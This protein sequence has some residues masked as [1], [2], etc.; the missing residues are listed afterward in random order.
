MIS[1]CTSLCRNVYI[2]LFTKIVIKLLSQLILKYGI[3]WPC[4]SVIYIQIYG[5]QVSSAAILLFC[6]FAIFN[7]VPVPKDSNE[8]RIISETG[9]TATTE[10]SVKCFIGFH[11]TKTR[12]VKL[13][14]NCV[15]IAVS[16]TL[17][18]LADNEMGVRCVRSC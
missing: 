15:R 5:T 18:T 2:I 6:Y 3:M 9:V 14:S 12:Q 7:H 4:F 17:N 11:P 1:D 8:L 16:L 10:T 13:Y